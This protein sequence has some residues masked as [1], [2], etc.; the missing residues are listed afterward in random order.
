MTKEK[1]KE[2]SL[3]IAD[4]LFEKKGRDIMVIDV[5]AVT[6]YFSYIIIA[7]A[8]SFLHLNALSK[9]VADTL[10]EL[11]IKK[12]NPS[13]SF[14]ESP[15]ILK[16]CG[17]LVIHILNE[18]ARTFYSLEKLWADGQVIYDSTI[19]DKEIIGLNRSK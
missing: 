15:W 11:K 16:D 10:D 5:E 4:T 19:S 18:E 1:I 6:P 14:T 8:D 12:I 17:F 3:K 2:Y 9:F 7:T 13:D